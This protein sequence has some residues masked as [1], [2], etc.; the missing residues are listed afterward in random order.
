MADVIAALCFGAYLII[1][2][3]I[4]KMNQEDIRNSK[5]PKIFVTYS[6]LIALVLFIIELVR[7]ITF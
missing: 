5:G 1:D 7:V 2:S 6:F 3:V 4:I